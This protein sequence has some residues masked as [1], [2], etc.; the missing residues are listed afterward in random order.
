MWESC[1]HLYRH[2]E[3]KRIEDSKFDKDKRMQGTYYICIDRFY[4]QKCLNIKE[5]KQEQYV[6]VGDVIPELF[7]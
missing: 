6:K 1:E 2:L 3:T 4:C 5:I 7:R